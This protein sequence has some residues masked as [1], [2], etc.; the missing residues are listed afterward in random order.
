MI[1]AGRDGNDMFGCEKIKHVWCKYRF[2]WQR[3]VS[4]VRDLGCWQ[5]NW[6]SRWGFESVPVPCDVPRQWTSSAGILIRISFTQSELEGRSGLPFIH[7]FELRVFIG[8]WGCFAVGEFHVFDRLPWRDQRLS[9]QSTGVQNCQ[10]FTGVSLALADRLILT[11]FLL[12]LWG[13]FVFV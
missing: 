4:G 9:I 7:R 13:V 10:T 8:E 1:V 2:R 6:G 5:L 11:S 12:W 3:D